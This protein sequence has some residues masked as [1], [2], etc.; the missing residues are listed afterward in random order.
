MSKPTQTPLCG[1]ASIDTA[2]GGK[3]VGADPRVSAAAVALADLGQVQHVSFFGPG[4]RSYRHF[5]AKTA[6]AQTNAIHRGWVQIVRNE[7]VIAFKIK[8]GDVEIDCA[9][10]K[11]STLT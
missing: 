2:M 7:L 4:I 10:F 8:I 3:R 6:A 11:F 5:H 9:L 1:S